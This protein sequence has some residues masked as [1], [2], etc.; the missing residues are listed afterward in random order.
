MPVKLYISAVEDTEIQ[1]IQN[2]KEKDK[3][4]LEV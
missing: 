4:Y 2:R 1:F 3:S